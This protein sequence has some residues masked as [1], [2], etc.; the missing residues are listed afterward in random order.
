MRVCTVTVRGGSKGVPGKNWRTVAGLPLFAHSVRHAVASGL[1]DHVV[2]TSD[3]PEVLDTALGHGATDV[4]VRPADLAS[5]TA[6]KVPAIVH[7]ALE[8]EARHGVRFDTIVD[9]DAT[10]PLRDVSDIVGAVELFETSGAESVITGAE[11][12]RSPYF[13]LVEE[14]RD[15]GVVSL[16]KGG[17]G[18]IRRQDAPRAFDMNAS[19]YVWKRDSVVASP[20]VWFP[21]TRLFEM[22]PERSFDIDSE[23]DFDIV[24][25]LM[26]R[27]A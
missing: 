21:S 11:A 14:D 25:M 15:T 4:V 9:L 23:L 19:I 27:K 1:F 12:H 2:V 5:D 18:I 13:N 7:A 22:P 8:V 3:A 6:G 16:S 26:E 17:L 24:S 10:S 20:G